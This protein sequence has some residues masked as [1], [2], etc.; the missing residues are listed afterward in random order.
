METLNRRDF[1]SGFATTIAVATMLQGRALASTPRSLDTWAQDVADLNRDLSQG[2]LSL[3]HWQDNI[4]RLAKTVDLAALATYLD[5]ERLTAT[6]EFP[7]RLAETADPKFPTHINVTGIERPW[8]IRFFGMRKSGAIIPHVHNNMSHPTSS[9]AGTSIR[10]LSIG[11]ATT[12]KKGRC[13]YVPELTRRW[14]QA[15]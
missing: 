8:F 11:Q 1:F 2:T 3:L 15:A 6:M 13:C 9:C 7:T 4:E 12:W 5:F 10:A 14:L